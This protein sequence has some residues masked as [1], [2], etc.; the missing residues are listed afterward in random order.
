MIEIC[1]LGYFLLGSIP[2]EQWLEMSDVDKDFL[3]VESIL[4]FKIKHRCKTAQLTIVMDYKEVKFYIR[5]RECREWI[6]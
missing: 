1:L 2:I 5:C 6:I 3:L 4:D